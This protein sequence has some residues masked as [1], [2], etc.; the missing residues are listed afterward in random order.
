VEL[1]PFQWPLDLFWKF[2]FFSNILQ[3]LFSSL[4]VFFYWL[5]FYCPFFLLPGFFYRLIFLLPCA[6][7]W[8]IVWLPSA[9]TVPQLAGEQLGFPYLEAR[10]ALVGNSEASLDCPVAV[11]VKSA[12]F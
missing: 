7:N 6:D 12:V 11:D 1:S 2:V 4:P 10:V 3:F 8:W 5:F 9:P